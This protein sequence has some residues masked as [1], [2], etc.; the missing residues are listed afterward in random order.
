MDIIDLL[1]SIPAVGHALPYILIVFG[2]CALLMPVLPVPAST[3][4][5]AYGI[6]WSVLNLLAQNYANAKNASHPSN[7]PAPPSAVKSLLAL[8]LLSFALSACANVQTSI[9]KFCTTDQPVLGMVVMV[10]ADGTAAMMPQA[11]PAVPIVGA[12]VAGVNGFCDGLPPAPAPAPG[13]PVVF[14]AK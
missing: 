14:P 3:T 12:V 11:G 1:N 9:Q 4:G 10:A 13:T 2:I 7:V 6:V 5:S 8:V